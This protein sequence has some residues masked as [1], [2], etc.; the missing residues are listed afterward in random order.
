M[1]IDDTTNATGIAYNFQGNQYKKM[2]DKSSNN[3]CTLG[4]N[5]TWRDNFEDFQRHQKY[6]VE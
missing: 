3:L 6:P 5:D 2:G 4:Y 1:S